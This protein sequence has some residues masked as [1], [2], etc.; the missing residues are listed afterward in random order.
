MQI[1]L[2]GLAFLAGLVLVLWTLLSAIETF[3]LP[4][5]ASNRLTRWVFQAIGL[6][7]N[8]RL[9]RATEY[10]ERD[11]IMAF[12]APIGLL[13]L[14]PTWLALISIGY[15]GMFWTLDQGTWYKAFRSS[16]SSLLTLGFEPAKGF[17]QTVLAFSE[18]TI[19]LILVA[20]LIAY[21]PTMY[22]AFSRRESAVTLL[23]VRAGDPPSALE[24]LL[25]FNR[26]HGLASLS[27][28]WQTWE[29]WFAEIEES[30]SSL[31]ALV[32]FRSPSPQHSW[33]TAAGAVLDSAALTLSVVDIA[34]EPQA[35][36]C[37]RAGYL[38][39]RQISDFFGLHYH[40]DPHFPDHPISI[41]RNE[42]DKALQ[43]LREG[44]IPLKPDVDQAWQDFGGWRINYD[45]VLIG[46]ANLIMAPDAPWTGDRQHS[47]TLK[48]AG[49]L[50]R[51]KQNHTHPHP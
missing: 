33:I 7:F 37:I 47:T 23:E 31:S 19:G 35:A 12:F 43:T 28:V 14:L 5:S 42:F 44:G 46:L 38:A 22:A 2:R 24:M 3:V 1:A 26:I 15:T 21:L 8:L 48:L 50:K 11:R 34:Y 20:L 30:H 39:L 27:A 18:A 10:R 9:K 40:D 45:E 16:G 17:A 51:K 4:R 6:I 25:R 32:F 41:S 49:F 13:V 29:T 36:L